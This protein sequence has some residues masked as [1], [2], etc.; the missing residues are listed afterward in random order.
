MFTSFFSMHA[1]KVFAPAVAFFAMII[2]PTL[3]PGRNTD[4]KILRHVVLFKFKDTA[5]PEQIKQVEAAF[6]ALP[7]KI[8]LIKSFE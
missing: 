8:N 6:R 3:T 5:T 4:E 1:L 2:S 7:S